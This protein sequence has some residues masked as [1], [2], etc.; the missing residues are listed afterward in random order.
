MAEAIAFTSDL[1]TSSVNNAAFLSFTGHWISEN[2]K[3]NHAVLNM[4]HFPELH[5]SENI[6]IELLQSVTKWDI[7]VSKIQAIVHDNGANMVKGVKETISFR[8]LLHTYSPAGYTKLESIQSELGLPKHKLI[9]DIQTRWN[10]TYY[11]LERLL[12]Q[13]SAISVYIS[14]SRS[15]NFENLTSFQ[16]ET[17]QG[18]FSLTLPKLKGSVELC[19]EGLRLSL[20]EENEDSD[21]E[22]PSKGLVY[23]MKPEPT[24]KQSKNATAQEIAKYT[25]LAKADRKINPY[26]WWALS[27]NKNGFPILSKLA[28]RYLITPASSVY[29]ER[30][31]S[32]AG[33][34]TRKSE[35]DSLP[36]CRKI[37]FAS[38]SAS[39][40]F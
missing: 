38:Q 21:P 19:L 32:E 5:T 24:E 25:A 20:D 31:F 16:W 9:Q 11:L 37:V 13:K 17:P 30:L 18:T 26:E 35:T 3:L 34:L 23:T 8:T 39:G 2:F 29:S 15:V 28:K 14:E 33:L 7:P 10:S 1:W 6:K 4:A 22:T 12:E 40:G 36:T 27:T